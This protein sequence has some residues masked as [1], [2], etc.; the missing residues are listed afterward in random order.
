MESAEKKIVKLWHGMTHY[1]QTQSLQTTLHKIPME[2]HWF[3]KKRKI[4]N[5]KNYSKIEMFICGKGKS[6][7]GFR[8]NLLNSCCAAASFHVD[9]VDMF[10]YNSAHTI[11]ERFQILNGLLT[12]AKTNKIEINLNTEATVY[13]L[14]SLY[15]VKFNTFF[16][17]GKWKKMFVYCTSMKLVASRRC[18]F[19]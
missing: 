16:T 3:Q 5:A 17:V 4:K 7:I 15:V 14:Q 11:Y 1:A 13:Q 6:I 2:I 19:M 9:Y 12:M 10:C 8:N 18:L